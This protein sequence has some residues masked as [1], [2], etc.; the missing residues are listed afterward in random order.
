[1]KE[2]T[3]KNHSGVKVAVKVGSQFHYLVVAKL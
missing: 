1:M 3:M 2:R